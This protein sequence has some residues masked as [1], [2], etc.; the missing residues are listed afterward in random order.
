MYHRFRRQKPQM[1]VPNTVLPELLD[2]FKLR[3]HWIS[4]NSEFS[5]ELRK[6]D[7]GEVMAKGTTEQQSNV[8]VDLCSRCLLCLVVMEKG[9]KW[10]SHLLKK[11]HKLYNWIFP[12]M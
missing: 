5:L 2:T 4:V 11:K 1:T 12:W 7:I 6:V 3:F 8:P 10:G 9:R